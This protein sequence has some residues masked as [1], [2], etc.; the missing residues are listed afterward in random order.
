MVIDPAGLTVRPPVTSCVLPLLSVR[1]NAP[2]PPS[3]SLPVVVS[4]RLLP[5]ASDDP[6]AAEVVETTAAESHVTLEVRFNFPLVQFSSAGTPTKFS[7]AALIV[8]PL[9]FR[10]LPAELKTFSTT[11]A[12]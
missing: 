9:R 6:K 10:E 12:L 4:V 3:V 11:L 2:A 7:A 5:S 1:L 8:P